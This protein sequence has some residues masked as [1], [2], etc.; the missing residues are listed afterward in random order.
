MAPSNRPSLDALGDLQ[1]RI[2]ALV[3]QEKALK[4]DITAAYGVGA[5]EGQHYRVT[6]STFPVTRLPIAVARAKLKALGV[7]LQ[8]FAANEETET[9]TTVRVTART[10]VNLAAA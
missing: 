10:G 1:A 2:A 6:V 3:S 4:A 9:Q 5:H 7:S 8:W